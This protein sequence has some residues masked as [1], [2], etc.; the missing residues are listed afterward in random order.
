MRRRSRW[1]R[2]RTVPGRSIG[3]RI[4]GQSGKWIKMAERQ[5]E[6]L[7]TSYHGQVNPP[8]GSCPQWRDYCSWYG[9]PFDRNPLHPLCVSPCVCHWDPFD[10]NW[11]FRCPIRCRWELQSICQVAHVHELQFHYP[12]LAVPHCQLQC[13][14]GQCDLV[15][16]F[17]WSH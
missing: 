11:R 7:T 13:M 15:I 8:K 12:G 17:N 1:T 6:C 4:N 2:V 3:T 16:L 14:T 9:T 5:E 10:L